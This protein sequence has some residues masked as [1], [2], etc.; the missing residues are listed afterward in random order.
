MFYGG[1]ELCK[2]FR[3]KALTEN[4]LRVLEHRYLAKDD[5]GVAIESPDQLLTRHVSPMPLRFR[6]KTMALQ[7]TSRSWKSAEVFYQM[8]LNLE[9]VPNSPTLMNA[10]RPLGQ[11]SAYMFRSPC[12]RLDGRNL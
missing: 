7:L 1:E 11:L 9:Y 3:K 10:G 2:D 4:A 8:I 12:W 6:T 5:N